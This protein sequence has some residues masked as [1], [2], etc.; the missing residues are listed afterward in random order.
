VFVLLFCKG[1]INYIP[2]CC[3]RRSHWS[4]RVLWQGCYVAGETQMSY[5]RVGLLCRSSACG[6]M[7]VECGLIYGY[8]LWRGRQD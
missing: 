7:Y 3:S 6:H 2:N 5:P 8:C 1:V 4:C